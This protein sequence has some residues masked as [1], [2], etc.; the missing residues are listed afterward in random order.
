MTIDR[1]G[2]V[3]LALLALFT[4]EETWRLRLPM[5]NLQSPGPAYM[6]VLL[7][8][9]LLAFGALVAAMGG[10]AARVAEVGW[11][12]WRHAV[13]ILLV[14]A[15]VALAL[16]RLGYRITI[17]VALAFLLGVLERRSVVT[18]AVFALAFAAGSFY[19][20]ETLLRVPL[21]RSPWGI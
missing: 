16:E 8:T 2:G 9:L 13:M 12:E 3:I 7:A 10:R 19:L 11:R 4:I 18:A 20:F 6:P 21:P 1:F 17:A 15:F 5:G 14:I